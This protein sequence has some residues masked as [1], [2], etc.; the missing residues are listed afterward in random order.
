M[1]SGQYNPINLGTIIGTGPIKI[2]FYLY[3]YFVKSITLVDMTTPFKLNPATA[4]YLYGEVFYHTIRN[5]SKNI[6]EPY[7]LDSDRL[8]HSS[9]PVSG[10]FQD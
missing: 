5:C 9:C 4:K 3:Y 10:Y 7:Y 6:S 1:Y 2:E 8:C